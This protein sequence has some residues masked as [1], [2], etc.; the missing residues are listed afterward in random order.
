MQRSL[1][2]LPTVALLLAV[3]VAGCLDTDDGSGDGAQATGSELGLVDLPSTHVDVQA[4][5]ADALANGLAPM[6]FNESVVDAAV[7]L[8]N[9][10]YEPTIEVSDEG[11]LFITGHTAVVDTTGAP[12]YGS[13][14]DGATWEQ[15]PFTRDLMMP[16]DL[17]GAT[18]PVTDEIFLVA[19]DDGYLYGVDIT[20]ATFPVNAWNDDGRFHAYFNPNAYD[21][22]Q[23]ALQADQ[24]TAAPLKDRPWA[25]YADGALLMVSNPAAGPAQIGILDVPSGPLG[26]FETPYG[27]GATTGGG[28]WNVCAGIGYHTADNAIP[29][30]PDMR[31]DGL[32]AVPQRGGDALYLTLGNKMDIFNLDV[33]EVF[34]HT[35]GGEITSVY[36][37]AAFDADGTLFVGISNNTA[38]DSAGIRTGQMR[39]AVSLDNGSSFVDRTFVVGDV[40]QG[41]RHFYMDGNRF[42]PGVF[43][44]WAIDGDEVNED[45]DATTFDWFAGHIQ[46]GAAGEP[47]LVNPYMIIDEGPM[48]SAHVTGAAVGPDG[49]GYTAMYVDQGPGGTPLSMFIQQDGP[50]MPVT[51]SL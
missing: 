38:E 49:R 43:V 25:A 34:P 21:E 1:R 45:G 12:V 4:L 20:L 28:K 47:V 46:V 26:L 36:G 19:G 31:D 13:W 50:V 23:V 3:G 2:A 48:P 10:L 44:V 9:D 16:G 35:T 41:V 24:C 30:I 37:Q 27:V 11:T 51:V 39:F 5:L 40:G 14:D 8:T 18:P 7:S 22:H 6:L 17:P 42:G 29:G 32:F 33:V 15:L